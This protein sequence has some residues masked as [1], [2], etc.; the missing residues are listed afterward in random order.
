MI[1][2][3][4]AIVLSGHQYGCIT[5]SADNFDD[6]LQAGVY[7]VIACLKQDSAKLTWCLLVPSMR[8][9]RVFDSELL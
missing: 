1:T 5:P 3:G 7:A 2:P 6:L 9:V 4:S 8:W